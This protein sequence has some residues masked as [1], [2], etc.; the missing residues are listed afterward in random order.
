MKEGI[1]RLVEDMALQKGKL[2]KGTADEIAEV[3]RAE[4]KRVS[5]AEERKRSSEDRAE[6]DRRARPPREEEERRKKAESMADKEEIKQQERERQ[7]V[8]A[9][10]GVE[11]EQERV[12][13]KRPPQM[14]TYIEHVIWAERIMEAEKNRMKAEEDVKRFH[15]GVGV[16]GGWEVVEGKA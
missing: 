16:G 5:E 14:A 10:E 8:A 13:S 6:A 11:Q 9:L 3:E 15:H 4:V 12:T 7:G 1:S 2:K